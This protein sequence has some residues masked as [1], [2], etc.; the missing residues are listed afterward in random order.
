MKHYKIP[1]LMLCF[2]AM[3][4]SCNSDDEG[5]S[6]APVSISQSIQAEWYAPDAGRYMIFEYMYVSGT[7]YQNLS[8]FPEAAETFSG[9]WL[10]SRGG[11]L[12]LDILYDKSLKGGDE[13]YYVLRCDDRTLKVRHTSLGLTLDFYKIVETYTGRIGDRFDIGYAKNHSDFSSATYTTSNASIADVD[14]N[15]QV[16]IKGA[17]LAFITVSSSAGTVVVKVDGGKRVDSYTARIS[18]TVDQIMTRH[19]EPDGMATTKTGSPVVVYNTPQKVLDSAVELL[20]YAY[21]PDTR[22][23]TLVEIHYS[24]EAD[25]WFQLD[26]EYLITDFYLYLNNEGVYAPNQSLFDNHYYISVVK[27]ATQNGLLIFNRDYISIHGRY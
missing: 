24:S 20:A 22:E 11:V 3:L 5:N 16:T 25:Q 8:T 13:A 21:D 6:D 17:G 18:E 7:V 27:T 14:D 19:G 2:A 4:S 10:Y 1:I 15:G 23:V 26:E 12:N 9:Q